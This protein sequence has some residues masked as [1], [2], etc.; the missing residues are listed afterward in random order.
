M[1]KYDCVDKFRQVEAEEEDAGEE[2]EAEA[3]P[4]DEVAVEVSELLHA[5]QPLAVCYD[6]MHFSHL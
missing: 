5:T 2:E 4:G 6:A 3:L 1:H